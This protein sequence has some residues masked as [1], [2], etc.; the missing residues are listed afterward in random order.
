LIQVY[1][2]CTFTFIFCSPEATTTT[3]CILYCLNLSNETL[4]EYKAFS[5]MKLSLT[6][7]HGIIL[8]MSWELSFF[9]SLLA[10]FP[11]KLILEGYFTYCSSSL[12]ATVR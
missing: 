5:C 2:R 1:S 12:N 4:Q 11:F 3:N 10:F 9:D 8:I 6:K 7:R